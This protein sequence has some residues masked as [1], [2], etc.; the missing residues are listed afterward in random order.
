[1]VFQTHKRAKKTSGKL[2][3]SIS[4]VFTHK[5]IDA[6]TL[7]DLED[8]LIQ[9]DLGINVSTKIIQR[10]EKRKSLKRSNHCRNSIS[11]R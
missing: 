7:E 2:T 8:I 6:A 4:K 1:M 9:S 11:Y 10:F 3:E 5:K